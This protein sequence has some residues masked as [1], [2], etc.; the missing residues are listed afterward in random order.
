[1]LALPVAPRACSTRWVTSSTASRSAPTPC[2]ARPSKPAPGPGEA[3]AVVRWPSSPTCWRARSTRS[4]ACRSSC[5]AS[6]SRSAPPT[7]GTR[8]T[9][10]SSTS[11]TRG[12]RWS[13]TASTSASCSPVVATAA[14]T[15]ACPFRCPSP[16]KPSTWW[17]PGRRP[18]PPASPSR[19]CSRTPPTTCPICR[20]TPVGTRPPS[21]PSSWPRARAACCST[22]T[23]CGST[24][25]TTGST[26]TTCSSAS[27]S[28]GWSRSTLPAVTR[29]TG[30]C[31][32]PTAVR[33]PSRCG[34]CSSACC[35]GCPTCAPSSSRRSSR[36]SRA[37]AY[38]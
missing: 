38:R 31:S 10:T 22:C 15:P 5:T 8:A 25:P 2:A 26:S 36:T 11:S 1:M 12:S 4:T 17:R 19:S 33:S 20:P 13:G 18:W 27:P 21:S 35:P 7:G 14:G 30:S 6:S 3:A 34:R 28:T 9:S 24:P 16:A 29:P 23:T 32:T 37:S